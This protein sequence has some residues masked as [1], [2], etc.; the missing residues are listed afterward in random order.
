MK[1]Q[2]THMRTSAHT[3][4]HTS[5]EGREREREAGIRW[6]MHCLM[7]VTYYTTLKLSTFVMYC[8]RREVS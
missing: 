6:V 3:H 8:T 5:H 1:E 2:Q 7:E 4:T